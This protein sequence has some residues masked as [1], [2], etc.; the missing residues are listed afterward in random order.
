V[1]QQENKSSARIPELD[2]LRGLAVLLVVLHHYVYAW[3]DNP[4]PDSIAS[5]SVIALRWGHLGVD[6]FFVLS[7]YLIGSICCSNAKKSGFLSV[8]FMKRLLRIGPPYFLLLMAYSVALTGMNSGI[9]DD[10]AFEWLLKPSFSTLWFLTPFQN[11]P[12]FTY[13]SL[14]SGCL[15]IVWSL[16]VE[17]QFYLVAP[18]VFRYLRNGQAFGICLI[19]ICISFV[20][21]MI[22][23]DDGF[24]GY[25]MPFRLDGLGMG[26]MIAVLL[27]IPEIRSRLQRNVV[28]LVGGIAC[29][30]WLLSL[31]LFRSRGVF[32]ASEQTI[33][34]LG[35]SAIVVFCVLSSG[36]RLL[37]LLRLRVFTYFS[38]ISFS[39]Y[40]F[41]QFCSGLVFGFIKNSGPTMASFEDVSI[42]A[43][44]FVFAIV[45]SEAVYRLVEIPSMRYGRSLSY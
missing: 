39:L 7:G 31:L 43:L 38:R 21:R 30:L 12:M 3:I 32:G 26:M 28:W 11:L 42:A 23:F 4:A 22:F 15:S 25:L 13:R 44:A 34:S 41:H 14:H 36:S 1:Y 40:L 2:G 35:F 18:F 33:V 6:L 29:F 10:G 5:Y 16:S 24:V 20:L 8:F 27:H 45:M 19:G 37:I 17:E 9:L